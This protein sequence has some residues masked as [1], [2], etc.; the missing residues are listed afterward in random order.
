MRPS[1][2]KTT[3]GALRE[4]SSRKRKKRGSSP[5]SMVSSNLSSSSQGSNDSAK[6]SKSKK[7]QSKK[8]THNQI[9]T[10]KQGFKRHNAT[11]NYQDFSRLE[12][13]ESDLDQLQATRGGIYTP[14][15]AVLHTMMEQSDAK[16]YSSIVSW[17]SHGRAFLIHKPKIFLADVLPLFFNHSK[18]SSFQ[19]QLSLYGF[20][21]L[22][23]EGPDRGA[24]YHQH[25]LRGRFF[26]ISHISRTRV[27]GT[28]VRT[29]SSPKLEPDFYLQMEPVRAPGLLDMNIKAPPSQIISSTP[30]E[31]TDYI[32]NKLLQ[33]NDGEVDDQDSSYRIHPFLNDEDAT[34][35]TFSVLSSDRTARIMCNEAPTFVQSLDAHHSCLKGD[36]ALKINQQAA[37]FELTI[38]PPPP[39][40]NTAVSGPSQQPASETGL[41]VVPSKAFFTASSST[42]A[43]DSAPV[44]AF[45]NDDD[46]AIFLADIDFENDFSEHTDEEHLLVIAV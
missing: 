15:P 44:L 12:P 40:P 5:S 28:W 22:T 6:S 14:F 4:S 26:L 37:D 7:S 18:L 41:V 29:S 27:K 30:I 31:S 8:Q 20:T 46:L 25:F 33:D 34:I 39:F 1:Q 23:H 42:P 24:Y 2:A 3:R 45:K 36:S 38:Q 13:S 17:Q 21:R 35:R 9:L 32:C 19:R 16:G 43:G 10:T 11:H